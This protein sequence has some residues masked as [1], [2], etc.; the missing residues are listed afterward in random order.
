MARTTKRQSRPTSVA[1]I[2]AGRV[3]TA[4]GVLL[5][6][7]GYR[8][9]AVSGR[10]SSHDR[11]QRYL[12]FA[13]F[14]LPEEASKDADVAIFGV[15]D[16]LIAQGCEVMAEG[17]AFRRRQRVIHLSGSVSLDALA[18][19]KKKGA[20]VLSVHPLQSVPDVETGV[21]RLPGSPFAVTATTEPATLFGEELARAVG[22]EPFLLP[23]SAKP[24]YHAAAVFCANY[25][26]VVEALAEELF[27]AAGVEN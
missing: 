9:A 19:A 2:G 27:R 22:G 8:V 6:R 11:A 1:L 26:V 25:L 18:A 4:L 15:P 7:A 10:R 13:Q 17:G 14:L 24:L 21:A 16:D 20:D 23:D 3:A 12:P 5:E